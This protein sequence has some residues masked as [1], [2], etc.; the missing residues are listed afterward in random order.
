MELEDDRITNLI[1]QAESL[2]VAK[3]YV[4]TDEDSLSTEGKACLKNEVT[5]LRLQ[6][7][8]LLSSHKMLQQ[9]L[10]AKG[11][12]CVRLESALQKYVSTHTSVTSYEPS[13]SV[14][15][16]RDVTASLIPFSVAG[17]REPTWP[18]FKA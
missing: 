15:S 11:Q 7:A 17:Q 8:Q 16:K 3:N 10:T 6:V 14:D 5:A 2:A 1:S 9:Q 12:L 13:Y 18:I 4:S